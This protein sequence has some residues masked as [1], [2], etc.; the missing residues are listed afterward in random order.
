MNRI[1]TPLLAV[2]IACSAFS[3]H[4]SMHVDA[5]TL[6]H[7]TNGGTGF[8]G[9]TASASMDRMDSSRDGARWST[10]SAREQSQERGETVSALQTMGSNAMP[11]APATHRSWGTPD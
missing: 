5:A 11:A 3:A 4:A 8:I 7:V 6:P 2:A 9:V 1:A 10:A